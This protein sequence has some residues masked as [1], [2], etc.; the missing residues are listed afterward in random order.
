MNRQ[1]FKPLCL[2][3]EFKNP[4]CRQQKPS[5]LRKPEDRGNLSCGTGCGER[6]GQ[7]APPERSLLK[8]PTLR[9]QE[10]QVSK[11]GVSRLVFIVAVVP[12]SI[13]SFLFEKI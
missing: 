9:S 7:P 5:G 11:R 8:T 4:E 13:L 12:C 1:R 3:A 6:V 2:S 10:M